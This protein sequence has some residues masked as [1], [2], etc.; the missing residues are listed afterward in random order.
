MTHRE[1]I[2]Q[3]IYGGEAKMDPVPLCIGYMFRKI[4]KS[5]YSLS[6]IKIERTITYEVDEKQ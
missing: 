5:G 3:L 4:K 6:P 2:D 1:V